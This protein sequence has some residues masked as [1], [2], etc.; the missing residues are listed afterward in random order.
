[1]PHQNMLNIILMKNCI[2]NV[3]YRAAGIAENKF[4]TFVFKTL[5]KDMSAT[6]FQFNALKKNTEPEKLPEIK[7]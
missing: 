1:V 3:Q 2:V 6:E 5:D 7:A 4:D